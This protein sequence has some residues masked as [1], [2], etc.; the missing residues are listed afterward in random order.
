MIT[1]ATFN[2]EDDNMVL[3]ECRQIETRIC[4]DMADYTCH[5]GEF[6]TNRNVVVIIVPKTGMN[7]DAIEAAILESLKV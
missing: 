5:S 6:D 1:V 7:K 3:K 4:T 2:T